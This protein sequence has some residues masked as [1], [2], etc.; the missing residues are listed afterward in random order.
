MALRSESPPLGAARF[1]DELRKAGKLHEAVGAYLDAA[2]ASEIP[3]AEIC[4][5]LARC[6]ARL[7]DG[8]E[9]FEWL[10][11]IVDAGD[12]FLVWQSA[13]TVLDK[14][15]AMWKPE[16]KR[17]ARLA[18]VGSYNTAQLASMLKLAALRQSVHLEV[19]E[20]PYDQY[21]QRATGQAWTLI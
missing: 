9:T 3:P 11:K 19:Y 5:K 1:G 12:A 20:A 4:L 16:L 8:P 15:F 7:G 13:S 6:H 17:S 14:A 10:A 2:Q 21:R 18:L